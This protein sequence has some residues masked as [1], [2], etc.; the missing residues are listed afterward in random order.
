MRV[1]VHAVEKLLELIESQ[2]ADDLAETLV[3]LCSSWLPVGVLSHSGRFEGLYGFHANVKSAG[4]KNLAAYSPQD[5]IAEPK[6][7]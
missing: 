5:D 3:S 2:I 7:I 6:S 1:I 4:Y